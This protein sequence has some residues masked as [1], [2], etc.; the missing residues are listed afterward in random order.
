MLRKDRAISVH[1]L[2]AGKIF[3]PQQGKRHLGCGRQGGMPSHIALQIQS[4][5][6]EAFS[7][8]FHCNA[9]IFPIIMQD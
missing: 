3:G 9:R 7:S 8:V 4:S 1:L 5:M 2:D 6:Q